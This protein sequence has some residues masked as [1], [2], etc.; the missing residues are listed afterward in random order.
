MTLTPKR[1]QWSLV[2]LT[3]LISV[4]VL[5]AQNPITITQVGPSTVVG[6]TVP[7]SGTVTANM[8]TV[9]ADPFGA[10]A[11]AS[12]ATGSISAKLRFIAGTGI[13]ITGTVAVTQSGAWSL[14]ANQS[15]NVAQINGVTPLMGAGNTGT[16]SHRVTV[17]TDQAALPAWGHG[18]TAAAVPAG[19]TYNG[20]NVAGNLRGWTAV[21]PTGSVF[22][23]QVD[24]T[25]VNGVTVST[26]VGA[27]G[28]GTARVTDV[29]SGTTGSAPPTQA[30]YAGGV[31][32]GATGGLL[33]GLPI[34]DSS[35][36]LNIST[37]TTT[38]AVTGVSG[39]HIRVCAIGLVVAAADNVQFISGTG[40]TC[41]TGTT[42]IGSGGTS[43]ASGYNFAANGGIAYGNGI[44][45]LFKTTS[46]GDSICVVTSAATQLSGQ[47]TYTIY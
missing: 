40:A 4:V 16:G 33:A 44:G 24:Y 1:L 38:L 22:A 17:A 32:S 30:A 26:G 2:F 46:T 11:D 18:A 36:G 42:G 7:V 41:G 39:R 45:T 47:I 28:T 29:A 21:N 20:L 6:S 14:S 10:N 15:V 23:G 12:S 13:P 27:A 37:A 8:G 35:S 5:Y 25:S 9:T 34:C 31:T 19:A 3:V 43:A